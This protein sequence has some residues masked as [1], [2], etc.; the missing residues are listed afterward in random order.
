VIKFRTSSS[1]IVFEIGC[2]VVRV[3]TG[4]DA[5]GDGVVRVGTGVGTT[6]ETGVTAAGVIATG[7]EGTV[8]VPTG[9]TREWPR[10]HPAAATAIKIAIARGMRIDFRED[11]ERGGGVGIGVLSG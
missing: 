11:G 4:V 10:Y 2:G 5:G 6:V 8:E 9:V 1:F 7:I 3:G